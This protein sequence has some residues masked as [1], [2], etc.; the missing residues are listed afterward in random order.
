L[1][2]HQDSD[3]G[4]RDQWKLLQNYPRATFAVLDGAGHGLAIE[5]ARMFATMTEEWLQRLR[6]ASGRTA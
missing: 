6:A 1:T 2:G 4:Y 3:V 5:Q